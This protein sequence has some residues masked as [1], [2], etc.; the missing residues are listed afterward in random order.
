MRV[1]YLL[2][3][4]YPTEKA[5]GILI[6]S[7]VRGFIEAG[8]TVE[9]AFPRRSAIDPTPLE[10]V[11]Y[12]PFGPRIITKSNWIFFFYRWIGVILLPPIFARSQADVVIANDVLQVAFAPRSKKVFWDLHDIPAYEHWWRCWFV[13]R[14]LQRANGIIST[15]QLKLDEL[16]KI[17]TL[18]PSIVLA[19]PVTFDEKVVRAITRASARERL[20]LDSEQ[21]IV[22]YAGQL[23]DWKGVDTLIHAMEFLDRDVSTYIVGGMGTDLERCQKL[24]TKYVHLIFVGMR[25]LDEVPFWL[26][27]ADIVVLPNSGRFAVSARDTNPM[28]AIEAVGAGVCM[29]ASDLP[30]LHQAIPE[31]LPAKFFR[32][33]DPKSCADVIRELFSDPTQ[34]AELL[35]R[36]NSYHVL[37]SVERALMLTRWFDGLERSYDLI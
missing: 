20:N 27:A 21:K 14:A 15:N 36:V 26:R 31:G 34:R 28:K 17:A 37:S 22:V 32:P 29:V 6:D 8:H 19:N 33:D 12:F 16:K 5:Y 9:V 18:P 11:Q 3:A 1:C 13:K 24:G 2:N 7:M 30:S 10:G 4:R 23:Y 25:P 35:S